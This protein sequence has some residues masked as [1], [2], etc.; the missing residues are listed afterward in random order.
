MSVLRS[1]PSNQ[2]PSSGAN[3]QIE[4]SWKLQCRGPIHQ[5]ASGVVQNPHARGPGPDRYGRATRKVASRA[6]PERIE[7]LAS[8]QLPSSSG[9]RCRVG[10]ASARP[11]NMFVDMADRKRAEDPSRRADKEFREFVENASVAMHW[12]RLG[13]H[14]PLGQSRRVG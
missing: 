6:K 13:W 4:P 5:L 1:P 2:A 3:A 11:V 9:M 14:H 7:L 12:V 8:S 10:Y